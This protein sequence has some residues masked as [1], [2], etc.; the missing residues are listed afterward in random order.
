MILNV[1]QG[2]TLLVDGPSSVNLLFGSVKVLGKDLRVGSKI[3]VRNG[4]RLPFEVTKDAEFDLTLGETSSYLEMDGGTIPKSWEDAADGVLALE[5]PASILTMGG[6]DSGKTSLC[7]YLANRMLKNQRKVAIIDGDLGQSDLGPPATVGLARLTEPTVDLFSIQP[8]STVFVGATTPSKAFHASLNAL[9][10]L[11]EKGL[12]MGT[13]FLIVNTDGWVNGEDAL[14]H[15]NQAVAL[16]GPSAIIAIQEG[17][18]LKPLLDTLHGLRI[19]TVEP[20]KTIRKRS[21]ETRKALRELAYRK[22]LKGAKIQS[23]PISWVKIRGA[24]TEAFDA[25]SPE[26]RSI[27]E[28]SLQAT[29][30]DY[31][32]PATVTEEERDLLVGLEDE[33]GEFLGIGIICS[34][35]LERRTIKVYT[36]VSQ[37]AKVIHTGRIRLDKSGKEI[38]DRYEESFPNP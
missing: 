20:P 7:T 11:R 31:G 30:A 22:Y 36:S 16:F 13:D 21:H 3:V 25:F 17:D 6:I 24:P 27:D 38:T 32:E 34:I 2:K 37:Q 28:T 33:K 12:E 14:N 26:Q 10:T 29:R 35:D 1:K 18:E 4:K 8:E 15:K 5:A 9:K 23:Y 19:F